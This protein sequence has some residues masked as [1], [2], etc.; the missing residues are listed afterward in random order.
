MFTLFIYNFCY[1]GVI[2]CVVIGI[3]TLYTSLGYTGKAQERFSAGNH[4]ISELGEIGVS[5]RARVFNSG[6]MISG[7]TLIPFVIGLGL[8]LQNVWAKL[9]ILSG[10]WTSIACICVG[11]FPMNNMSPHIKAAFAYFRGGLVT[12]LLFSIAILLQ[13]A[14]Q[15]LI[16]GYALIPGALAVIAYSSFLFLSGKVN[17]TAESPASLDPQRIPER[18]RIWLLPMVEWAV[19]FSTIIWFFCIAVILLLKVHST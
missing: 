3:T 9:G 12:V 14:G 15:N 16:P 6:L 10:L 7:A 5:S 8:Y 1:F 4:Y 17:K 13:P 18:P 2:G 11:L 19:F